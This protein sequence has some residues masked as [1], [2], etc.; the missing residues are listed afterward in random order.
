M[1]WTISS[2]A[3]PCLTPLSS[4][5]VYI[6]IFYD[7]RLS[8]TPIHMANSSPCIYSIAASISSSS[9]SSPKVAVVLLLLQKSTMCTLEWQWWHSTTSCSIFSSSIYRA[10]ALYWLNIRSSV[11]YCGLSEDGNACFLFV[12]RIPPDLFAPLFT[13][14][15]AISLSDVEL[16]SRGIWTSFDSSSIACAGLI[17]LVVIVVSS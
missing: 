11:A 5:F 16:V 7:S 13:A 9:S 17:L 1:V 2:F 8:P 14:V 12:T 4:L 6:C 15:A 10:L 3:T